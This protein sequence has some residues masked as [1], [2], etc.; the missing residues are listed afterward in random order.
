MGGGKQRS[1]SCAFPHVVPTFS[2]PS[3]LLR[4]HVVNSTT[5]SSSLSGPCKPSAQPRVPQN[6]RGGGSCKGWWHGHGRKPQHPAQEMRWGKTEKATGLLHSASPLTMSTSPAE[7]KIS[8]LQWL[9]RA[10][11]SPEMTG[12]MGQGSVG[13]F[14]PSWEG[15]VPLNFNRIRVIQTPKSHFFPHE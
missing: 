1:M 14:S 11:C 7:P 8:A 3:G 2:Q 5:R 10:F 15:R 12:D 6:S 13:C 4:P 9:S